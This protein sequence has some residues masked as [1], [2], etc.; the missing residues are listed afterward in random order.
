MKRKA[1]DTKF[2]IMF[3]CEVNEEMINII[4]IQYFQINFNSRQHY[5]RC[6]YD[7]Y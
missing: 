6:F 5:S 1:L 3:V 7:K 4:L 2:T